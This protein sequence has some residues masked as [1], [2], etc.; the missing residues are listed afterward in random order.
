MPFAKLC[1]R[2]NSKGNRVYFVRYYVTGNRGN[3][4]KF[5]IGNVSPRRAKEISERIRAMVIQGVDPQ[6]FYKEQAEKNTEETPKRLR[7]TDLE[8]AYLK[9]CEINN[10]PSTIEIKKTAFKSLRKK[11]GNCY[12]DTVTPEKVEG[13]MI[14]LNNITK[15]TVNIKLRQIRSMFNWG[16][17]RELIT[18]NPFKNSGIKQFKVPD[19][20]PEDY[21]SLNE[22]DLILDAIKEEKEQ[23]YRLVKLALETGG[24]RSELLSLTGNDIDLDNGRVLFRGPTTKTGQR[25][26]VPLRPSAVIMLESWNIQ[27]DEKIF[28]WEAHNSVSRDFRKVL[29]RLNL[30]KT[31]TGNRCFHTLR[32]TYASH[33]LMSGVNIFTVSRWLGH[34]SVRVT[35]KHYGHL[36][37]E[38]VTVALPWEY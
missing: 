6:D 23:L 31:T 21:F 11:L 18:N 36:I 30:R 29:Q 4:R 33:L 38:A 3:E 19:T 7:L 16:V 9:Y 27:P 32:H 25:R 12:V 2:N 1:H 35:E 22:I 13:W 14:S 26:Y 20:D 15:T 34:S 5:T 10:Q 24:R 37:P 28:T 8:E 17:K